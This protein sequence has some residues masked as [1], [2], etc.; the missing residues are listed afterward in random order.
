[1]RN[2]QKSCITYSGVER[3]SNIFFFYIT[4]MKMSQCKMVSLSVWLPTSC[5]KNIGI[6]FF[7]RLCDIFQ[8]LH[9]DNLHQVL[10]FQA[11]LGDLN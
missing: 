7:L 6:G 3:S 11:S 4:C 1:M 9:D 5:G 10:H 2:Y 8:I